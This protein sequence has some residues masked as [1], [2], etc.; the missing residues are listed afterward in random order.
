MQYK[1][2]Q[3]MKRTDYRFEDWDWAKDYFDMNDYTCVYD[4][5]ITGEDVYDMLEN[6]FVKFNT[7]RPE[8]FRGHSLSV[9]DVVS[10]EGRLFYCDI[11][12]WIEVRQ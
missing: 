9:S 12:G 3:M 11:C 6:I 8:D 1:I 4:G 5:Q 2:Y 7:R 10:L